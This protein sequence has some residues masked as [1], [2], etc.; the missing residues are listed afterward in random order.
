[1]PSRPPRHKA[2][3]VLAAAGRTAAALDDVG[4]VPTDVSGWLNDL[5]ALIG[6]PFTYLVPDS[7]MLPPESI[8]FFAVDPNWIAAMVDGALSVGGTSAA[9]AAA[10]ATLRPSILASSAGPAAECS[11]FL[12]RS[13][14]VSDWPGLRVAGYAEVDGTGGPLPI[15]R[16]ERVAPT[17]LLALFAG[18]VTRVDLAEPAQHLHFGVASE[19]D[20]SVA[21]RWIDPGRAGLQL[22]NDPIAELSLRADPARA[23]LDVTKC[24]A[25]IVAGLTS[26]YAPEPV[27]HLGS[28]ALAVQLALG[29]Q[30][31]SFRIGTA[32]VLLVNGAPTAIDTYVTGVLGLANQQPGA[33]ARL[34]VSGSPP[35]MEIFGAIP[36]PPGS[37]A[38]RTDV[39][40]LTINVLT[41]ATGPRPAYLLTAPAAG[42]TLTAIADNPAPV[43]STKGRLVVAVAKGGPTV[44]LTVDQQSALSG[45]AA[46]SASEV[47]VTA[48]IHTLV[49]TSPGLQ[50]SAELRI[51]GSSSTR[52]YV[53][54]AS[55]GALDVV[56]ITV[57]A[58]SAG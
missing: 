3:Q 14:A 2:L 47:T 22:P 20:P 48:G 49:L 17:V 31:Q 29:A 43:A 19:S 11:G 34:S 32:E 4:E 51:A 36:E 13:A 56:D 26:A 23:V 50:W 37:R 16:L 8:R 44:A 46:G 35:S 52:L 24:S 38:H 18:L 25:A 10:V 40:L 39:P 57:P 28:G 1:M 15:I 5:K 27:P 30:S 12:L 7:R 42:A 58:T 45:V 9:G 55:G 41:L 21:L 54:G 6:V 53:L 33:I